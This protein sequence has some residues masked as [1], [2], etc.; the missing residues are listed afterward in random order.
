MEMTTDLVA[1]FGVLNV[2]GADINRPSVVA[3]FKVVRGFLVREAHYVVA[4]GV[5]HSVMVV[6]GERRE[7]NR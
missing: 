7:G 6:L 1:A 3:Q 5:H 4:V 2:I